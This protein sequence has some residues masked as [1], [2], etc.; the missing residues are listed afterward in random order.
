MEKFRKSSY[1]NANA[2]QC[3]EVA[4]TLG[5]VRDSKNADGPALRGDVALLVA[6]IKASRFTR[7]A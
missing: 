6:D 5:A 1:S 3:V 2:Q 4:N 7:P